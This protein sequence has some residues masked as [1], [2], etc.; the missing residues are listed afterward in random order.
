MILGIGSDLVELNRIE[1]SMKR[2][3]KRF[4]SRI[5]SEAEIEWIQNWKSQK[6]IVEWIGG[7][8]AAKEAIAKAWGT[9]IGE[10]ISFHFITVLPDERGKPIVYLPEGMRHDLVGTKFQ[11]HVSITHSDSHA[12]A[13]AV[14]EALV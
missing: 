2:F 11:F 8:F 6:R 3:G 1:D 10:S 7:R 9:G 12:I 14:L 4:L 5:L 13:F